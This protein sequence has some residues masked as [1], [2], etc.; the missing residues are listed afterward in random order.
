[1]AWLDVPKN[2]TAV[3]VANQRLGRLIGQWGA[4]LS[5]LKWAGKLA[6]LRCVVNGII[7]SCVMAIFDSWVK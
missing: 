3:W 5:M 6:E 1:M 2:S 7:P 4:S